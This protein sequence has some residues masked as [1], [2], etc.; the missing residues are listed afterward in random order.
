MQIK[1]LAEVPESGKPLRYEPKVHR[2]LRVA[3]FR[4][5]YRIEKDAIIINCFDH[6]KDVYN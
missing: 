3:P 4:I 6:E 1:K 5:I 2:T